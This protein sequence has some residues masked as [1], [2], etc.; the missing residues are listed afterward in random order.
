VLKLGN[1][2]DADP[3]VPEALAEALRDSDALVRHDAVLAVAKL[4]HPGQAIMTQLETMS[5]TD[6]DAGVRDLSQR[7]LTTIGHRE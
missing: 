1:V 3:I 4:N 7:A 5:R 2:G 6:K